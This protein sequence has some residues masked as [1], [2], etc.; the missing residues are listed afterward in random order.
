MR[1]PLSLCVLLALLAW[2]PSIFS[3]GF[4]YD[5][6]EAIFENPVVTGELPLDAA[7]DR[8]YWHH[9]GDAGH[10][11]PLATVS[12]R[13]DHALWGD[14]ARGYHAT[15]VALHAGVVLL[16]GLWLQRRLPN[17]LPWLG[18][19]LFAAHP[20]LADS[21]AWLS[22]RTSMLSAL[23]GLIGGVLLTRSHSRFTCTL[24][25]GFGLLLALCAKEDGIVFALIYLVSEKKRRGAILVGSSLAL[26]AYAAL[27]AN[28]LGHAFPSAPGAPLAAT[29]LLERLHI[30]GFA[31]LEGLRLAVFPFRYPP[32]YR[33]QDLAPPVSLA[34]SIAA[35]CAWL[36]LLAALVR[37]LWK[38]TTIRLSAAFAAAVALPVLQLIP[39]GEVFAPRFLYPVLL[40]AVPFV[41]AVLQFFVRQSS[42]RALLFALLL[43]ICVPM[44][45]A[46]STVYKTRGSY[47]LAVLALHPDDSRSWNGL[48]HDY[49]EQNRIQAARAAWEHA[50]EID[51]EYSRPWTNL[52]ISYFTR[53]EERLALPYFNEAV[54]TGP[55]NPIAHVWLARARLQRGQ[56]SEACALFERAARLAPGMSE[57]WTGLAEAYFQLDDLPR[58]RAAVERA[59]ELDPTAKA[60]LETW[61]RIMGAGL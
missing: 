31:I 14:D 60:V 38:P 49:F 55:Q 29:P 54:E 22:G 56:S 8:D 9:R 5:D 33:V 15:N 3:S 50:I 35:G 24:A 52:G 47:R 28:A 44:A 10:Y 59:S 1:G 17:G 32:H 2:I 13:I 21:V 7:F 61:S 36:V 23:G 19:A 42:T 57:A 25:A 27:R 48:G 46:R 53:G 43:C 4:S 20:V 40:F 26:C 41:G 37:P 12:L 6:R 34:S 58:A 16:L 18:L 30:G 11:R 39:A 51:P 45:W